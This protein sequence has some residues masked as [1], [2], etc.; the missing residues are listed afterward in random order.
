[1]GDGLA[2][3]G[4]QGQK[5]GQGDEAP[6]AAAHGA[7]ALF[8]IELLHLFTHLGL[9]VGVLFLDLLN[10]AVH[11]AHADHALLGLHLEWQQNQLDDQSEQ[12]DGNTVRARQVIKQAQQCREGDTNKVSDGSEKSHWISSVNR[13][14]VFQLCCPLRDRVVAAFVK[15]I[16]AQDAFERQP[17]A[18]AGAI[19][20]N[21]LRGILGAGGDIIA[22]AGTVGRD[23]LLIKPDE[24]QK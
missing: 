11:T 5:D 7:D 19:F 6:Q 14:F 17:A 15:R 4:V 13:S 20:L 18:L 24:Q 23:G 16:A 21:G 1:M 12:D 2:D 8:G 3:D 9:V 22:A 10:F